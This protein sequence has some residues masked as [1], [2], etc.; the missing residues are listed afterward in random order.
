MFCNHCEEIARGCA[1]TVRGVCGRDP[2]AARL[3]DVLIRVGRGLAA[4]NLAATAAGK[5]N[6]E[7][8]LLS[9]GVRESGSEKIAT[10]GKDL[11]RRVPAAGGA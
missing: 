4:R 5:G 9:V 6:P 1:C 3:Q 7:V 2:G 8:A 11:E 10:A